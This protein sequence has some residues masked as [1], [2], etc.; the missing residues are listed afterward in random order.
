M[1]NTFLLPVLLCLVLIHVAAP[2]AF[3]QAIPPGVHITAVAETKA[4]FWV[5]STD[6]L[7]KIC[8]KTNRAEHLTTANSGLPS[9]MITCICAEPDG[10]LW[11]GTAAGIL[12]YDNYTF[13]VMNAKN[14]GLPDD[15]ITALVSDNDNNIWIGTLHGGVAQKLQFG[16]INVYRKANSVLPSDEVHSITKDSD[17]NIWVG[18]GN[19]GLALYRNGRWARLGS[20]SEIEGHRMLFVAKNANQYN[21]Y[22]TDGSAFSIAGRTIT[23]TAQATPLVSE[24]SVKYSLAGNCFWIH[25]SN[26]LAATGGKAESQEIMARYNHIVAMLQNNE[27]ASVTSKKN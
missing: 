26:T 1:K 13:Y 6:G 16:K 22:C 14:S 10:N 27:I 4:C 20:G 2:L 23:R 7:W 18:C 25:G 19:S 15:S 5:G 11:I 12:R 21:L 9:Q 3:G 17:G 24:T 8:K